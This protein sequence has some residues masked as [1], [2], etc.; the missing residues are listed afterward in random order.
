VLSK[1]DVHRNYYVNKHANWPCCWLVCV[2]VQTLKPISSEMLILTDMITELVMSR[3]RQP[4][5]S[6]QS[7]TYTGKEVLCQKCVQIPVR[8]TQ[9]LQ[10]SPSSAGGPG[11]HIVL[12]E[13]KTISLCLQKSWLIQSSLPNL[14]VLSLTE[15]ISVVCIIKV[16]SVS[17]HCSYHSKFVSI[18]HQMCSDMSDNL[19]TL[20]M[21]DRA[22]C[23]C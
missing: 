1:Y 4:F 23:V 10:A 6:G 22:K 12:F 14:T 8:E 7:V 18:H 17:D 21:A 20:K 9:S 15:F 11:T 3:C 16:T 5:P 2:C 13:V 19:Q